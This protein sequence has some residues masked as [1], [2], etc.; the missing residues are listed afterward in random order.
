M[1][2]LETPVGEMAE[3]LPYEF[4]VASLFCEMLSNRISDIREH[5]ETCLIS[6]L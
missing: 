6:N 2:S 4:W 5:V 3:S 1:K